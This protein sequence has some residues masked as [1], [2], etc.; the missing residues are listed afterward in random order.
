[1]T[2]RLAPAMNHTANLVYELWRLRELGLGGNELKLQRNSFSRYNVV[3]R[4]TLKSPVK[5]ETALCRKF[6]LE[7]E[8]PYASSSKRLRLDIEGNYSQFVEPVLSPSEQLSSTSEVL[9]EDA[10]FQRLPSLFR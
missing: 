6:S 1:M 10:A 5:V 9:I 8:D 3:S 7:D 2:I 4:K